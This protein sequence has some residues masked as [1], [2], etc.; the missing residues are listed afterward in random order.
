MFF[1][2]AS[3][4]YYVIEKG[5]LKKQLLRTCGALVVTGFAI[6]GLKVLIDMCDDTEVGKFDALKQA[7]A[8]LSTKF[9]DVKGVDE[10]KAD[11]EDIVLYL[12]DPKVSV[13]LPSTCVHAF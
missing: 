4:P 11:L 2:T 12:R 10:A 6:Y 7:A 1:G 3:A 9:S 5:L 8:D 13:A